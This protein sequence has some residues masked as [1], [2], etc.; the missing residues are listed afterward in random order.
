[1]LNKIIKFYN[2]ISYKSSTRTKWYRK[3]IIC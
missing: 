2:S 1:L 3:Y